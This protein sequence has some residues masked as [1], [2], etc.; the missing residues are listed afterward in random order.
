LQV[1]WLQ[2]TI[3]YW[4]K[5]VANKANSEL[6]D[7]VLDAGLYQ[8]LEEDHDCWALQLMHGLQLAD[9]DTDWETHMLQLKAID[10]PKGV[11]RL[12]KQ[13]FAA[14]I[15]MFDS[16]PTDPVCP[17]RKRSTYCQW[18]HHPDDSGLI[19]APTYINADM[20]LHRK[21]SLARVRLGCAPTHT[22]ATHR[23]PYIERTCQRCGHGVDNEH[24]MLFDC[25]QE[26]LVAVRNDYS[27]LFTG[28]TSV[29]EL[30]AA[31]YNPESV[32]SLASCMH[33]MLNSMA[34]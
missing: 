20:P 1:Q 27:E 13:K 24:H 28:V 11:T 26:S 3:S 14:S 10:S 17:H 5:L 19:R 6:L 23:V 7:F 4:N 31:A 16:D 8:G 29:R 18:M 32:F 25:Q 33:D 22:N 30:M 12:A 21:Q 9:P 34:G 2:R 15:Q